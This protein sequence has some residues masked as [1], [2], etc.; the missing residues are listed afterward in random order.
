MLLRLPFK[1]SNS[2]IP[3]PNLPSFLVKWGQWPFTGI[4]PER[5]DAIL[6]ELASALAP[7]QLKA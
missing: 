3:F 4:D 1:P 7:L 2:T 5:D 6:R